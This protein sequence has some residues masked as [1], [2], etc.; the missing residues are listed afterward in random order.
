MRLIFSNM[1][2]YVKLR[3]GEVGEVPR[4]VEFKGHVANDMMDPG[5][6]LAWRTWD[7]INQS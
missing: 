1:K 2:A 6:Q 3:D 4:P 7:C 5:E